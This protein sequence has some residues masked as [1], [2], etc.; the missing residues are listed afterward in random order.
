[1][2]VLDLCLIGEGSALVSVTYSCLYLLYFLVLMVF[3]PLLPGTQY[4][5]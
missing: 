1:M 2:Q 3:Y 4:G 5:W